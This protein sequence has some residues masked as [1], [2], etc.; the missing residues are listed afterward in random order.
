ML[1]MLSKRP[2]PDGRPLE[3]DGDGKTALYSEAHAERQLAL[4]GP[5]VDLFFDRCVGTIRH[6]DSSTRCWLRSHVRGR[7]HKVPLE[8]PGRESTSKGY[9]NWWKRMLW[10]VLHLQ[11]L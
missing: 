11:C 7:P 5:A 10:F 2:S 3:L 6:T 1:Q 9:R 4:I 8:L